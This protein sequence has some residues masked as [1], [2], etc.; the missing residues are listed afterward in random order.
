MNT[1][2]KKKQR[3]A[4]TAYNRLTGERDIISAPH[5]EITTREMLA[6]RQRAMQGKR[7]LP[8]IRLRMEPA[9]REGKIFTPPVGSIL[10]A[11]DN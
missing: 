7:K 4:I 6:K 3:Y 11:G 1:N 10:K 9:V 5:S 2:E 8:F